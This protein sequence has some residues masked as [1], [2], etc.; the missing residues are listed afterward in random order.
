MEFVDYKCLEN[1]LI[2]GEE[3]IANEGI[4]SKIKE[5]RT[6]SAAINSMKEELKEKSPEEISKL[7]V[8]KIKTH[9]SK[10]DLAKDAINKMYEEYVKSPGK[11]KMK[12]TSVLKNISGIKCIITTYEDSGKFY[13]LTV[14]YGDNI[15]I[16][17]LHSA[18]IVLSQPSNN[19]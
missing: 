11:G 8:S 14:P 4:F 12:K 16:I 13:S 19:F 18:A 6:K 15:D 1:L 17:T 5:K 10:T 7:V 9:L 3:L 2:E